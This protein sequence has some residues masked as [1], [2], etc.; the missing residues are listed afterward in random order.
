MAEDS[1][2]PTGVK[3]HGKPILLWVG[4]AM[5]ADEGV[6]S[7]Q[8]VPRFLQQ[9]Q[10]I[11]FDIRFLPLEF[12]LEESTEERL[13]A[14]GL[15]VLAGDWYRQNLEQWLKSHERA[16]DYVYFECPSDSLDTLA[17][18][19]SLT[20]AASV[21][22]VSQLPQDASASEGMKHVFDHADLLL[23][24]DPEACQSLQGSVP[25]QQI[26]SCPANEE[27][28][29]EALSIAHKASLPRIARQLEAVSPGTPPRVIAFYLPQYHPIPENDEIGR[30]HV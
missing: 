19:L 29:R 5:D 6:L 27:Q 9:L 28:A 30:A 16:V 22:L 14:A 26:L 8:L 20:R 18:I 15:E 7:G 17:T 2:T 1:G 11:G 13:L 3:E 4:P 24:V 10:S 21:C 23:A 12:H 25:S